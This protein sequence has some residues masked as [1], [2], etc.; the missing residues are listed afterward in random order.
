[1]DIGEFAK[2]LENILSPE[3]EIMDEAQAE[4]TR[5]L[6]EETPLV[7][8]LSS[9]ILLSIESFNATIAAEAANMIGKCFTL[10]GVR[11][12]TIKE[13]WKKLEQELRSKISSLFFRK[14]VNRLIG[15]CAES[16]EKEW[17]HRAY[18]VQKQKEHS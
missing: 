6:N 15:M 11:C 17:R 4:A 10:P 5:L 16:R 18:K 7:L 14:A 1:M 3:K 8:N 12:S 9:D 2:I 13:N